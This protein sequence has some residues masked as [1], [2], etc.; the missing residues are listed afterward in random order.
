M[1][2]ILIL[3]LISNATSDCGVEHQLTFEFDTN[4][5]SKAA[6]NS[7]SICQNEELKKHY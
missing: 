1:S 6:V 7:S 5:D 3:K 4:R 2:A